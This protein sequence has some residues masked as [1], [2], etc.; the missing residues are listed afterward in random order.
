[1]STTSIPATNSGDTALGFVTL[2]IA[3]FFYGSFFLPG[4]FMSI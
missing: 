4:K 1:M 3:I 2:V